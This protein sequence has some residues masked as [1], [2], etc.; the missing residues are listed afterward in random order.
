M[1][2]K[3]FTECNY[4]TLQVNADITEFSVKKKVKTHLMRLKPDPHPITGADKMSL[5]DRAISYL[6]TSG[7]QNVY[8]I[9]GWAVRTRRKRNSQKTTTADL[10][11]SIVRL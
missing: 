1:F 5:Y 2:R 9:L 10:E 4:Y 7:F 8:I 3:C 11:K 6:L